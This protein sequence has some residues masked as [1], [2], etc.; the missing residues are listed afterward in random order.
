MSNLALAAAYEGSRPLREHRFK[1]LLRRV[2]SRVGDDRDV[3]RLSLSS[4]GHLYKRQGASDRQQASES[5]EQ[6]SLR[7]ATDQ[8]V[9]NPMWLTGGSIA[10][11]DVEGAV[12]PDYRV[13]EPDRGVVDPRYL[14]HLLRSQP[15]RDQY[16]LFIRANT[17]FDRR[18]QQEDLD[19]LPVWLPGLEEQR[20]IADFLDDRVARIDQIITARRRQ[21][22]L[23]TKSLIRCSLEAIGGG[24][25]GPRRDSGRRW[26]GAIPSQWPVLTVATE[27]QVDLGK[28]LDEKRQTGDWTI[29]YL[30]N[31][32]VQWDRVVIDDLK[33][34]DIA[35]DQRERFCVRPGDLLICE[36]GQPGRSAVW[37]GDVT[38]L[39]FQKALHRARSRGRSR[40]TWLLECLRVAAHLNVFAVENGQTTIG[41][42][43]NEQLRSLRLPFPET[44]EQDHLL[45]GLHQRQLAGS[46]AIESM[47]R[48]L[49]TL[50]EY[51]QSL[52]TVAVTGE[53]DVTTAGSGI[54]G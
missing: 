49:E 14:H 40:A 12:S 16:N 44:D 8:L 3:Q 51:K 19:Q 5:T 52:I 54:P 13:F 33:H 10:V 4:A 24:S 30:R 11:S 17:T 32:N 15:Y 39:G 43:T 47:S 22:A 21:Q 23:I 53:L 46:M 25:L 41:H 42:L 50:T 20:R 6:R 29:P 18:I 48:S 2:E 26:L 27:F 45:A 34:M 35:S 9:V 36:G 28:M 38:P 7:V 31:T 1:R 37:S